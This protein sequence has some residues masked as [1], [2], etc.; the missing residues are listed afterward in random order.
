[1][2]ID[3]KIGYLTFVLCEE[4]L[5]A[6]FSIFNNND[7]HQNNQLKFCRFRIILTRERPWRNND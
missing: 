4:E 6:K 5:I 7:V 3:G 2:F 1:M